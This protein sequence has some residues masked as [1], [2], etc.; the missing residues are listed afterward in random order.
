[1]SSVC[2]FCGHALRPEARFCA[3]CGRAVAAAPDSIETLRTGDYQIVRSISKGGMGAIYLAR[4]RHAFGRLCVIKQMLNYF[5]PA[6][7]EERQRAEERFEEEGRTLAYLSHP[8]VPKIYTFFREDGLYYIVMEYIQGQNLE[9]F[10]THTRDGQLISPPRRLHRE[11]VLRHAV[12][13]GRILEYLHSQSRPVV[14]QDIKPANLILEAQLGDV[15]LVDFGTASVRIAKPAAA[16]SAERDTSIYGTDGYAPPEQYRGHPAP[17]SDVFALAATIYHL[18]TDDD[19]RDHPFKWPMLDTLPRDL[20]LAL[21]KALRTDIERRSTARELRQS[22]EALSTPSR[23]LE[24]FTFPGNA[25]IRTVGALPALCDEHWDAARRFLYR[26]DFQRW[27]RDINRHDL[28]VSADQLV[29]TEQN[30]DAGLESF[31]RAVDPGLPHPKVIVD[32]VSIDLGGVA[33]EAALIQHLSV[34]NSARGYA[35]AQVTTDQPWLEVCPAQLHLWVNK[36]VDLSVTVRGEDLPFRHR[37]HGTVHIASEGLPALD[38]SVVARVSLA[39]EAWRI[40][41]RALSSALP[42]AGRSAKAAW[43]LNTGIV[44]GA[45]RPFVRHPWLLSALWFLLATSA[46]VGLFFGGG[47]LPTLPLVGPYAALLYA[48][49]DWGLLLLAAALL[50]PTIIL[51]AWLLFLLASLLLSTLWGTLKGAW[52]SFA[53]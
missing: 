30:H 3:S 6:D 52:K 19:P 7:T 34:N 9:S 2:A 25:Q 53:Q 37:Q 20:A 21:R 48:P 26:G 1:M 51:A 42:E 50:P 22:L 45:A 32:Q 17:R 24:V 29:E 33:R 35:L 27:L 38:V 16:L 39:R 28:V 11:E 4:D 47:V 36:P 12:Q 13:V 31:V 43:I 41:W 44:S 23:T 49:L 10:V 5:D 15:R 40:I 8:G 14:H 46:G 18:L